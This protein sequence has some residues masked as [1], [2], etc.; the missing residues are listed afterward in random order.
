MFKP[1]LTLFS[2]DS[3]IPKRKA[4]VFIDTKTWHVIYCLNHIVR[5]RIAQRYS[6]LKSS[7]DPTLKRDSFL[8]LFLQD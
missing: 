6:R 4:V 3:F 8:L 7:S 2:I 5:F 1:L